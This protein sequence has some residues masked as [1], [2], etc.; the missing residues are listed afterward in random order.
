VLLLGF[1]SGLP[2][3]LSRTTLQTW[4]AF[5]KVDLATL[6]LLMLVGLP[7]SLKFLWSPL[8]DRFVPPF[9]SRRRG[10]MLLCQFALVAG[11]AALGIVGVV[12][13][14]AASAVALAVAFFSASQDIT[15]DAYRTE[16]LQ[17]REYG[18]GG[19]FAVM[20]Y[21][22]GM[23]VSGSL[24]LLLADHVGW[25]AAYLLMAAG[26]LVGLGTT[27]LAPAESAA[28]PP[29]RTFRQAVVTPLADFL[30][31]PGAWQMLLFILVYKLDFAMVYLMSNPF[32]VDQGYSMGQIGWT[33]GAGIVATMVGSGI[34]GV[35]AMKLGI[36]R[37]LWIFGLLQ[38]LA[39]LSFFAAAC[40]GPNYA[41]A[42]TAV[43]TES[44][45]TGMATAA[46]V[47]FL[48]SLCNRRFTATQYALLSAIM[49]LGTTVGGWPMGWLAKLAGWPIY[50]IVA[51]VIA[52]PGLVLLLNYRNWMQHSH[53]WTEPEPPA[54]AAGSDPK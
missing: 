51:T 39:G 40:A 4:M 17:P 35:V 18:L 1:A 8:M 31:R 43:I 34:G 24:P 36:Q 5:N 26:M 48:M 44:L 49:S 2:L 7:Y 22:V 19:G 10:W 6:G 46:F 13:P 42:T 20:G 38:G 52:V 29:P 28:G 15:I 53:L 11:I 37:A 54:V 16:I 50:F 45:C 12:D 3:E 47:G 9:L 32:L 27:L 14:L 25:S 30:R 41:L 23:L 33:R 21:R